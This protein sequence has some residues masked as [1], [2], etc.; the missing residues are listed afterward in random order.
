MVEEDEV[1]DIP[2]FD[3]TN[4]GELPGLQNPKNVVS[5]DEKLDNK[6][7]TMEK[8]ATTTVAHSSCPQ[9]PTKHLIEEI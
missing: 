2:S 4:E 5:L 6:A 9:Q 8:S 3:Q 7:D 1:M